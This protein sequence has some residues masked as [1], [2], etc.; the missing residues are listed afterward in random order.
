[1]AQVDLAHLPVSL[2]HHSA[3]TDLFALL[4]YVHALTTLTDLICLAPSRTHVLLS[5]LAPLCFDEWCITEPAAVLLCCL[6]LTALS[7]AM[8]VCMCLVLQSLSPAPTEAS[9]PT[10]GAHQRL[11]VLHQ[12]GRMGATTTSHALATVL[13]TLLM[14]T[15]TSL[16][17]LSG[18]LPH[19]AEPTASAHSMHTVTS[20]SVTSIASVQR[21]SSAQTAA[22]HQARQAAAC[23]LALATASDAW[24]TQWFPTLQPSAQ[25]PTLA[26]AQ[27]CARA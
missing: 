18:A 9:V 2:V 27:P 16:L 22:A 13:R 1:M 19:L 20:L 12:P 8:Y 25:T 5:A 3:C 4:D 24:Q 11:L 26:L 17:I 21:A 10:M 7:S 6:R 23:Q 14:G 15:A